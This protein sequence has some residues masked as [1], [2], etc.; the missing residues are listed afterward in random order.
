MSTRPISSLT[1]SCLLPINERKRYDCGY[2]FIGQPLK[3]DCVVICPIPNR[4]HGSY[5]TRAVVKAPLPKLIRVSYE[6]APG[7]FKTR[8]IDPAKCIRI[9]TLFEADT[10]IRDL[11]RNNADLRQKIK[12]LEGRLNG[13][14][15]TV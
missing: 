1:W 13:S 8:K 10:I 2:D 12:E 7:Y 9:D 5:L 15:H 4:N 3:V 11:N 14:G 6:V